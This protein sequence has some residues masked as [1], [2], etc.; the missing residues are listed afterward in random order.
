MQNS[1]KPVDLIH[2]DELILS[3]YGRSDIYNLTVGNREQRILRCRELHKERTTVCVYDFKGETIKATLRKDGRFLS[4]VESDH[5][6]LIDNN[7]IIANTLLV[8]MLQGKLIQIEVERKKSPWVVAATQNSE[9][10]DRNFTVMKGYVVNLYPTLTGEREKMRAY[11]KE[12]SENS[13]ERPL[14]KAHKRKFRELTKSSTPSKVFKLLSQSIDSM[15]LIVWDNNG[16]RGSA[17]CFV[18]SGFCIFTCLHI[19]NDIVG[20]GIDPLRCTDLISQCVRVTFDE[21]DCKEPA[22]N[23]NSSF[24]IDPWLDISDITLDYAVLKLKENGQVPTG[25]YNGIA[26]GAAEF[27]AYL[28]LCKF[29]IAL[30]PS[31]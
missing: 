6:K 29:A 24:C 2:L 27:F 20:E 5:W 31:S 14:F 18:F 7:T 8:D 3:A 11:I 26:M 21:E 30:L 28:F 22:S 23:F 12:E 19:L 17:T 25:L 9:L 4:F 1:W 13:K 10:E 16:N 15:G